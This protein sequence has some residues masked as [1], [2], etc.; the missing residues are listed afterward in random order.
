MNGMN[1]GNKHVVYL[2]IKPKWSYFTVDFN[3]TTCK[4]SKYQ[5]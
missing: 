2:H 1:I 5:F 4:S 3:S